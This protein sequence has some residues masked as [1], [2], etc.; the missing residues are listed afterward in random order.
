MTALTHPL[1]LIDPV[2]GKPW[3]HAAGIPLPSD[4]L[5]AEPWEHIDGSPVLST[6]DVCCDTCGRKI[7]VQYMPSGDDFFIDIAFML[8]P[9]NYVPRDEVAL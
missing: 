9:A 4:P 6:D 8:D 2:C 3:K 7:M 5:V 1:T